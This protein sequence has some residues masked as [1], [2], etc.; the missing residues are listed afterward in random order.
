MD[1]LFGSMFSADRESDDQEE[2]TDELNCIEQ[3]R[4]EF[5][6]YLSNKF[7]INSD[8]LEWWK[9]YG[10][11]RYPLTAGLAK[12]LLAI[13]ATS[14][15]S[16]RLFSTA[17]NLINAKR[18]CLSSDNVDTILFLNKNMATFS[19]TVILYLPV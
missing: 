3:V 1:Q 10:E 13:P 15:P 5:K 12:I 2:R 9:C 4:V 17:G 6:C 19:S 11:S 14:V 8:P 7:D 16:E 18:G